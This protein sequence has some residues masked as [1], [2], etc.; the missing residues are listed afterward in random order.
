[1]QGSP[2]LKGQKGKIH[3]LPG[4]NHFKVTLTQPAIMDSILRL[5]FDLEVSEGFVIAVITVGALES[6]QSPGGSAP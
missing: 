4:V 1:M 6:M 3:P 5:V 2:L